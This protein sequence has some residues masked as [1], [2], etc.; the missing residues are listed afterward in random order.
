MG[1]GNP[2]GLTSHHELAFV[3]T[4]TAIG[5][6]IPTAGGTAPDSPNFILTDV[7]IQEKC[8]T[9]DCVGGERAFRSTGNLPVVSVR[10][11]WPKANQQERSDL[12]FETI[13]PLLPHRCAISREYTRPRAGCPCY[14]SAPC[15][16]NSEEE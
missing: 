1:T 16:A 6:S 7:P 8:V 13:A 10:R 3:A 15:N 2:L 4:S 5:R 11:H 14:G 12:M 9:K